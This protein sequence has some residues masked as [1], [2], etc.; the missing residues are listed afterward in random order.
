MS[1]AFFVWAAKIEPNAAVLVD[2]EGFE[3][4][5]ELRKGI[6]HA[7]GFPSGVTF[8]MDSRKPTNTLLVDNIK[9]TQNVVIIS[10]KLKAFV[11]DQGLVDVEFL[12]I[13]VLDHKGR[14]VDDPFYIFH[15]IENVDCIDMDKTGPKWGDIDNTIIKGVK[16]LVIDKAL[17]PEDKRYFR[18]RYYTARPIVSKV[19]AD[20][21]LQAGFTGVQ[22]M[23]ISEIKGRLR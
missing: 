17:V 3:K 20:A 4:S 6:S 14:A 2:F 21:I 5:H 19:L 12:P 15:P 22:F 10:E 8:Q 16:Q 13:T 1:E 7:E 18:P 9:N 23:P 11:E